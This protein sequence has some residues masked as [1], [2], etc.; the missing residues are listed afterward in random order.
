MRLKTE[1]VAGLSVLLTEIVMMCSLFMIFVFLRS[2]RVVE[3]HFL[4]WFCSV[5]ALYLV[6][7][8]LQRREIAANLIIGVNILTTAGLCVGGCLCFTDADTVMTYFF[9]ALFFG[10]SGVRAAYVV[11]NGVHPNQMLIYTELTI[12]FLTFFLLEQNMLPQLVLY[13]RITFGALCCDLFSLILIRLLSE[14]QTRVS[15][16]KYQGIFVIGAVL[17]LAGTLAIGLVMILS[18]NVREAFSAMIGGL[19]AFFQMIAQGFM[20]VF[21]FLFSL[22]PQ[23]E[24]VSPVEMQTAQGAASIND[25]MIAANAGGIMG[26][27]LVGLGIF[28]LIVLLVTIVRMRGKKTSAVK[29]RQA[30]KEGV[31]V[32][33]RFWETLKKWWRAFKGGLAFRYECLR[34]RNSP[35]WLLIK[36]EQYAKVK[37][38]PRQPGESPGAFVRRLGLWIEE[39]QAVK[40]GNIKAERE[41]SQEAFRQLADHLEALFYSPSHGDFSREWVSS[42]KKRISG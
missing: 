8:L 13:N 37:K 40:S 5:A 9:S 42:I 23:Q 24:A 32:K 30:A 2:E 41:E 33:S 39:N 34:H 35:Q 17:L 16:S 25:E 11:K 1:D 7:V 6:N 28:A 36:L 20:A 15:G 18:Q 22:L 31:V 27:L 26:L 38:I 12:F 19:L 14:N 4:P 21:A 10:I 3:L 29:T